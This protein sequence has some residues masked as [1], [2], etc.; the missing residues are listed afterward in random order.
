M[1]Q[2][3]Y[4]VR[5]SLCSHIE[6]TTG[7][8]LISTLSDLCTDLLLPLAPPASS[9][10]PSHS[11]PLVNPLPFPSPTQQAFL[12]SDAVASALNQ[13]KSVL[14]AL[15]VLKKVCDHPGLL[16]ENASR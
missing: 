6:A 1:Q 10:A 12:E 5:I 2:Q 9:L 11:P 7:L 14:A 3:I 16:S 15:T 4:K 8:C 13:S